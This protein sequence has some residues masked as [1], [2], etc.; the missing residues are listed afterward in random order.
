[1]DFVNTE[2]VFEHLSD[3]YEIISILAS[4]LRRG[5]LLK[6][7]VP[8]AP[9]LEYRL[10]GF[11]WNASPGRRSLL[12]AVHPLEHVNC[13]DARSLIALARRVG[14][15]PVR[16]PVRAYMAFVRRPS[17][18]PWTDPRAFAKAWAR[19]LY[20]RFSRENLYMWFR[21]VSE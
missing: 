1:M 16:I 9:D 10:N 2:Q 14:L 18:I 20:H 11:D 7:S 5:G 21:R 13:F 3:P 12:T 19:P 17:A 15:E 8:Q 4:A 6:I